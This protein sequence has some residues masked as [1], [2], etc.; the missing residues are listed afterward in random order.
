MVTPR[1]QEKGVSSGSRTQYYNIEVGFA[2]QTQQHHVLT[3]RV[4]LKRLASG[5][6]TQDI[7]V[8]V[9]FA[10]VQTQQHQTMKFGAIRHLMEQDST[11]LEEG[12]EWDLQFHT[13]HAAPSAHSH[14][15]QVTSL[16][17][18]LQK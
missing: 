16:A 11:E 1:F 14:N 6:R 13:L 7:G 3:L 2:Q 5:S 12:M 18:L 8:V 15:P 10:A 4:E 17:H 9:G